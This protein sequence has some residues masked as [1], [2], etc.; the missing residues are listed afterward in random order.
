MSAW[1]EDRTSAA[2]EEVADGLGQRRECRRLGVV[3]VSRSE[4]VGWG[5]SRATWF[6]LKHNRR[7]EKDQLEWGW[8]VEGVV[9]MAVVAPAGGAGVAKP[10]ED[11][12]VVWRGRDHRSTWR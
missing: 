2:V 10:V 5:D 4:T 3:E 9:A 12:I 8:R 1:C 11:A 7:I 6:E